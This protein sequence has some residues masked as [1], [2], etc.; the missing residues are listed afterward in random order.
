MEKNTLF[1]T[2]GRFIHSFIRFNS[3]SK[4]HKN[5][6]QK[7]WHKSTH[8]HKKHRKTMDQFRPCA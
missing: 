2:Q 3:G 1:V 7:Q 5:N 4:A 8:K 6:R